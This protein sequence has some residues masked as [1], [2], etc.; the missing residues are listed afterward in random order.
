MVCS[1]CE[2]KLSTVITPEV[3]KDGS[4]NSVVGSAGRKI[5][6]NKLLSSKNKNKFAPYERK[7]KSCASRVHQMGA[8]YCQKCAYKEGKCALCGVKILDTSMYKQSSK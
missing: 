6:D 2:K 8:T 4:K 3:W 7:C 5:N 1:K